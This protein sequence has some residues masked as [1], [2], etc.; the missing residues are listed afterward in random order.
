MKKIDLAQSIALFANLGVIAGIVFLAVEIRQNTRSIQIGGYQDLMGRIAQM[1]ELVIENRLDAENAYGEAG[2]DELQLDNAD[3]QAAFQMHVMMFRHGDM[4]FY[5]LEQDVIPRERFD[6]ATGVIRIN[7]CKSNVQSTWQ[8]LK[9]N[10]SFTR[11]YV[12]Y[13]DTLVQEC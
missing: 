3:Y 4:A 9:D 5:Q 13:I 10:S 2:W 1:S 6:T 7:I 12:E 8:I 11:D